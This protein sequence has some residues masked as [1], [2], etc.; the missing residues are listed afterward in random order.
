MNRY[1]HVRYENG[2]NITDDTKV[3]KCKTPLKAAKK[4]WRIF[5]SLQIIYV[6]DINTQEL[7]KFESKQWKNIYNKFKK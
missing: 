1:I 2:V 6:R 7:F 5:K 3:Y 4:I